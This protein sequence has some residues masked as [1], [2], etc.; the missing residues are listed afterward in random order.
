MRLHTE[1]GKIRQKKFTKINANFKKATL[2]WFDLSMLHFNIVLK[3][4]QVYIERNLHKQ[5]KSILN[6]THSHTHI[7]CMI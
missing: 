4:I 6:H 3:L 5:R 1:R 7:S 2:I